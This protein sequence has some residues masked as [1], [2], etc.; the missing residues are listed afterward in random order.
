M[1]ILTR[2][3]NSFT[4]E[5]IV[6]FVGE[7]IPEG[8]QLDYKKDFPEKGLAK[9][10][11]SFANTRGGVIIIGV[12]EDEKTGLPTACE[13]ILPDKHEDRIYQYIGNINPI[14]KVE[15]Q[16]IDSTQGKVFVLIRVFEGDETPYYVHNDNNIW[17][18]LNQCHSRFFR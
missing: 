12:E 9:I 11:A 4:F 10:I 7:K 13:G 16:T 17:I 1:D 8:V 14:P 18:L 3:L 2:Q 5:D 6:A 15:I